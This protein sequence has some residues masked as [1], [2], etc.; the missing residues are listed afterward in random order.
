MDI[1]KLKP[2]I[3]KIDILEKNNPSGNDYEKFIT[4]EWLSRKDLS[5]ILWYYYLIKQTIDY[6]DF[7]KWVTDYVVNWKKDLWTWTII[8]ADKINVRAWKMTNIEYCKLANIPYYNIWWNWWG[9]VVWKWDIWILLNIYNSN[10]YEVLL[11]LIKDFVWW[12]VKINNNDILLNWKKIVWSR[13]SLNRLAIHI[14]FADPDIEL[15]K[16]ICNKPMEKQPWWI[17]SITW[18]TAEDFIRYIKWI[19]Q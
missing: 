15:I 12:D 11:E 9:I 19:I 18:K 17:T 16:K 10:E 2:Y 3:N 8:I 1:E 13:C 14:S 4:D 5:I 6:V 7:D